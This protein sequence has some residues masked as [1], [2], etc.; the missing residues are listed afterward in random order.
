MKILILIFIAWTLA[1]ILILWSKDI[2]AKHKR[3]A[4]VCFLNST[5]RGAIVLIPDLLAPIIVPIALLFTSWDAEKLPWLFTIWDNDLGPNGDPRRYDGTSFKFVP[6]E[7]DNEEVK[8]GCYWAEG[9]HPRSFWARF[10]WMGL[11]NRASKGAVMMGVKYQD[12]PSI[13]YGHA[14]V[15]RYTNPGWRLTERGGNY[16]LEAIYK[17]GPLAYRM[18]YGFKVYQKRFGKIMP[19]TISLSFKSWK[20]K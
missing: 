11:R 8:R 2:P 6:L 4:T 10:V 9:H 18:N 3:K 5:W 7:K 17:F 16:Q 20:G 15:D 12:V 1:P 13:E 14:K 19:I